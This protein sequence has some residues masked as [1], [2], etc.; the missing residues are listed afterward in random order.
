MNV[1]APTID[2]Y[3]VQANVKRRMNRLKV[4]SEDCIVFEDSI[5]GITAANTAGMIS[6]GIGNKDVLSNANHNF[7]KFNLITNQFLSHL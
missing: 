3:V 2:H 7:S 4:K 1:F 6:I 5:S